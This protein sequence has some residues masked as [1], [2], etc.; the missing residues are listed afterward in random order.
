[1]TISRNYQL[2]FNSRNT[3][4]SDV[5]LEVNISWENPINDAIIADRINAWLVAIGANLEVV[6]KTKR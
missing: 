2:Q 4:N 6:E 5:I 1:M 3:S